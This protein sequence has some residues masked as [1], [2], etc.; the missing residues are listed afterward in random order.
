M[1]AL[2]AQRARPQLVFLI[3]HWEQEFVSAETVND[4]IAY[5]Q[6]RAA[7]RLA[8]LD[9][10]RSLASSCLLS[11]VLHLE[12]KP[13]TLNPKPLVLGLAPGV[14][15]GAVACA[16][17]RGDGGSEGIGDKVGMQGTGH[18]KASGGR[19]R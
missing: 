4:I 12:P 17:V 15:P 1:H 10:L 5:T 8:D 7:F 9:V 13:Q 3:L 2:P 6:D 18:A 14:H 11:L 19:L 16:S